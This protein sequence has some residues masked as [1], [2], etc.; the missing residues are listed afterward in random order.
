MWPSLLCNASSTICRLAWCKHCCSFLLLII[1]LFL[2]KKPETSMSRETCL[3]VDSK[4]DIWARRIISMENSI[5]RSRW[6]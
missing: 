6:W 4:M 2:V 5:D 3:V 1:Y